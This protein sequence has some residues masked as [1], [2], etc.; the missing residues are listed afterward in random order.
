MA[1]QRIPVF[2]DLRTTKA[3]TSLRIRAVWCAP[4][5]FTYWKVLYLDLQQGKLQLS[6]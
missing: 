3:H 2:G 1:L 6:S 5:L 4:L